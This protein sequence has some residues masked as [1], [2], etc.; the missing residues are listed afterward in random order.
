MRRH[1]TADKEL[2]CR[3]SQCDLHTTTNIL[4]TELASKCSEP[5]MPADPEKGTRA[6]A[7]CCTS[8]ITLAEFKT[9]QGKMDGA[10]WQ[11]T[12]VEDF[13]DGTPNWRTDLNAS[14]GTLMTHAESIAL[15]QK[16]GTKM[17]PEL[18][19]PQVSMPYKGFTQ[20]DYAKKLIDEYVEAG[21]DPGDMWPQS[22]NLSDVEYWSN[23]IQI[24]E[25]RRSI[26]RDDLATQTSNT[27]SQKLGIHQWSNWQ[28]AALR[29]SLRHCGC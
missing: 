29:L 7:K 2:V 18:K 13:M 14:N 1:L 21:V 10:N 5:F 6:Q 27:I 11:A 16:L 15:F 25:S 19:S 22:F 17:I 28:T 3:H 4:A 20:Q 23:I 9:L 8:D 24:S 12:S 26:W